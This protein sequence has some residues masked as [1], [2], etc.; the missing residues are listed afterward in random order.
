MLSEVNGFQEY[1]TKDI[2]K[3]LLPEIK[4]IYKLFPSLNLSENELYELINE[5]LDK[6]KLLFN[7]NNSFVVFN[8]I[9]NVLFKQINDYKEALDAFDKLELFCNLLNYDTDIVLLNDLINKNDNFNNAISI[10]YSNCQKNI[11][12]DE[13]EK[14]FINKALIMSLEVYLLIN[15]VAIKNGKKQEE[16]NNIDDIIEIYLKDIRANKLLTS[17]KEKILGREIANG[18]I[19]ARNLLIESN[20]RLVAAVAKRYIGNGVDYLDLIQEGNL[21]LIRAVEKYDYTKG[22]RFSTYAIYWISQAIRR[23]IA[24]SSKTI[25]IPV[26]MTEV[27]NRVD[28]AQKQLWAELGRDATEE[29]IAKRLDITPERVRDV[30]DVIQAPIS[31]ETPIGT[32]DTVISELIEDNNTQLPDSYVEEKLLIEEVRELLNFLPKREQAILKLRFGFINDRCY[33][34]EEIGRILNI[35][36]QRVHQIEKAALKKLSRSKTFKKMIIYADHPDEMQAVTERSYKL[37]SS[38]VKDYFRVVKK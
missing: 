38:N 24:N 22:Y 10:V 23:S 19:K 33:S 17:D 36:K 26:Q 12:N 6:T 27:I 35:S 20:L 25:R 1:E 5:K 4:E 8:S 32:N 3:N 2:I 14:L 30:L 29:E 9:I 18:N 16:Y 28:A 34:F 37:S 11:I 7:D 31:L 15:G 13:A 21:G